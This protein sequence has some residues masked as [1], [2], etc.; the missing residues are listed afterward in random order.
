MNIKQLCLLMMAASTACNVAAEESSKV[1]QSY[2]SPY[3]ASIVI[4][5][6]DK[7][8]FYYI[9]FNG[10]EHHYDNNV[11]LYQ[12]IKSNQGYN[13]QLAG[14]KNVNVKNSQ[15]RAMLNGTNTPYQEVL[16]DNDSSTRIIYSH[17]AD[18]VQERQIKQQYMDR[19]FVVIS[20]VEAKKLIK[21]A[22]QKI[23]KSC[24]T[25]INIDIDWAAFKTAGNK[26]TPS[27][28]AAYLNGLAKICAIDADYLDA[29]KTIKMIQ[30][31]PSIND[32]I[33]KA[34]LIDNVLS[35]EI[36][37]QVP[38]LPETSYKLL[39]DIF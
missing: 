10:F 6:A 4:S 37:T 22:N 26:T 8:K 3:D 25:S 35:L 29:V 36:G 31:I 17:T 7:K 34:V 11:L 1:F 18:I 23:T 30:I 39:Y 24:L 2:E 21:K 32:D 38:N 14:M 27:K 13:Y 33:H 16:L 9:K 12:K 19:Q 5:P 15:K 28:T 20:K